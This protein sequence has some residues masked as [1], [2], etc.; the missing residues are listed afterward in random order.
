MEWTGTCTMFIR[1]VLLS[2]KVLRMYEDN[3]EK[4]SITFPSRKAVVPSRTGGNQYAPK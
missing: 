2:E 4:A 3:E 1:D